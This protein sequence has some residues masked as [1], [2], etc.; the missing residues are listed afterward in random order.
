MEGWR[1]KAKDERYSWWIEKL[2]QKDIEPIK[3]SLRVG[4][5]VALP[6][7]HI[8]LSPSLPF[9][10]AAPSHPRTLASSL[11]HPLSPSPAPS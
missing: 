1:E 4:R 6:R 9:L 5:I 2:A 11:P 10:F 7:E 8:C 3:V